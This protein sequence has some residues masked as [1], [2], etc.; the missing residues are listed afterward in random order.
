MASTTT[1]CEFVDDSSSPPTMFQGHICQ[2]TVWMIAK[3]ENLLS[4][5]S[6]HVLKLFHCTLK[7]RVNIQD[8]KCSQLELSMNCILQVELTFLISH[9]SHTEIKSILNSILSLQGFMIFLVICLIFLERKFK[10]FQFPFSEEVHKLE[11][12]KST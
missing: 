6:C 9:F 8:P 1:H 7:W 10:P 12:S 2:I 4:P 3:V 11:S 5:P